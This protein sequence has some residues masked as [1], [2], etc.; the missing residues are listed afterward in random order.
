MSTKN[1]VKD[2]RVARVF[3]G[4]LVDDRAFRRG[5]RKVTLGEYKQT[6]LVPLVGIDEGF[7][8]FDGGRGGFTLRLTSEMK[9]KLH[10]GGKNFFVEE[11]VK[12]PSAKKVGSIQASDLSGNKTQAD[13]FEVELKESDWGLIKFG[14]HL[15]II[16]QFVVPGGAILSASALNGGAGL[17]A[18]AIRGIAS[19]GGAAM[20]FA[21][22]VLVGFI[23]STMYL[24][25]DTVDLEAY[26]EEVDRKLS[27]RSDEE[28]LKTEEELELK[29]PEETE[30]VTAIP[31]EEPPKAAEG[32]EGK[33]GDPEKTNETKL[34]KIDG[35]MVD[36]APPKVGV[37]QALGPNFAQSIASNF[38][39]GPL[40]DVSE[41]FV[42]MAGS[43]DAFVMG[44]G[45]GGMGM[46]GS[47]TGGGGGPGGG[48]IGGIGKGPGH[49]DGRGGGEAPKVGKAKASVK[50]TVKL[51]A[52]KAG[53]FCKAEDIKNVVGK[54]SARIRN[55]YERRLLADPKLSGKVIAQWKIQLDGSVK[56]AKVS[57]STI[58]DDE[59]GRCLV[60]L[61]E[62]SK[63][64]TPDGGICVVEYPFTFVSQ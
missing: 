57:S 15:E 37:A 10:I 38:G 34:A 41:Q 47:G 22:L 46:A 27:F 55:C 7:S 39:A 44:M 9:G 1:V 40:G 52:P 25:K 58:G 2:L 3:G 33:F 21:G 32:E 24:H 19:I 60:R 50:P 29:P 28:E 64:N 17:T 42:G 61:L 11:F 35:P 12:S 59:V 14:E 62:T 49:G 13:V 20:L 63:F 6:L 4:R 43:G 5:T 56:D 48:V 36:K 18:G 51:E 54:K 26:T 31:D 8:L 23:F 30:I 45:V 16:F 53:N